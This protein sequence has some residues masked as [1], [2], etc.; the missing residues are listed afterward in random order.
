M[1]NGS[2]AQLFLAANL[3]YLFNPLLQSVSLWTGNL[4]DN[5]GTY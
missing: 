5:T 3:I 1:E 4:I 2:I